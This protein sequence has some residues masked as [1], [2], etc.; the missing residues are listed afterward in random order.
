[1]GCDVARM[2]MDLTVITKG[3]KAGGL[4]VA[5]EIEDHSKEDTMVT[6]G[7]V[8]QVIHIRDTKRA[9]VDTDGLGGGVSDRLQEL[10]DEGVIDCDI[11]Q[12]YGGGNRFLSEAD[13]LRF[14]NHK[15]RAY[16]YLRELFEKSNII[17]P[18]HARLKD[19]LSK[20]KWKPSSSNKIKILDPGEA[21][22]DKSEK[23]S[24]DF[25]DSLCYFVWDLEPRVYTI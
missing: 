20:M 15:A 13:K 11:I 23:K 10:N 3:F 16:F 12:F 21:K 7:R 17:I 18:D 19:Q 24:P 5:E 14:L 2:G 4:Y 1:M 25:A 6:V 9:C 22:D 8:R